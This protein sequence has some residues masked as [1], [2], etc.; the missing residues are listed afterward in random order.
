MDTANAAPAPNSAVQAPTPAAAASAGPGDRRRWAPTAR[1]A[2]TPARTSRH[3][4]ST[5]IAS[6]T[7]VIRSVPVRTG[8]PYPSSHS[9]TAN[10][11]MA[12]NRAPAGPVSAAVS[13]S[14][15]R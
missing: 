4:A 15:G 6:G 11:A 5:L 12:P 10:R 8:T 2:C 3:P 1:L 9:R 7:N 14:S 13:T